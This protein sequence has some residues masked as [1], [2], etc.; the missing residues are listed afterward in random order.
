VLAGNTGSEDRLSYTL[1]GD[2]VNL[3]SRIQELTKEFQCDILIS[4][5]AVKGLKNDFK[6]KKKSPVALKGYS[7]PITVFQI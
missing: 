1:I 7:T 6:M 2:T 5:E 4:A 3:A